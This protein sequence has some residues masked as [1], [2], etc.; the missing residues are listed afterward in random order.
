[1]YS[2]NA[3]AV[4]ANTGRV[5][6]D[7]RIAQDATDF[8]REMQ[9]RYRP[10]AY[11]GLP[12]ATEGAVLQLGRGVSL[13]APGADPVK[14]AELSAAVSAAPAPGR[15]GASGLGRRLNLVLAA[16]KTGTFGRQAFLVPM[17]GFETVQ[18]RLATQAA[19]FAELDDA[20]VAFHRAVS[21]EGMAERVTVYTDTEFNRTLAPN[22][23]GVAGHA[24]GGHQLVLGGSTLGG[25]IYGQFPSLELGGADDA[26]GNGTWRPS[27]SSAQFAA[28]LAYWYG[29]SDLAGVPEYAAAGGGMARRLDFLTE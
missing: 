17:G 26:V 25:R 29:K 22:Q 1:L 16:M 13:S 3:L 9:V 10:N 11:L 15:L 6:P 20:L 28:T 4:V 5:A 2:Q 24:W 18:G 7:H 12:W 8:T 27:T 21:A 14:H 23:F 19:L